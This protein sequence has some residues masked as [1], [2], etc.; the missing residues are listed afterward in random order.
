MIDYSEVYRKRF[1]LI[2]KWKDPDFLALSIALY[3]KDP[4]EFVNTWCETLDPRNSVRNLPNL[5]PLVLFERQQQMVRF[6]LQCMDEEAEGVIEKSREVGATWIGSAISVWLWLFRDDFSIGWGSLLERN[7]DS[8][9]NPSSIFEKMRIIIRNL[10]P[11]LLPESWSSV[12]MK[13]VNHERNN[14]ILGE[15]GDNIGRG[16]RNS[17]YFIDESAHLAR[18]ERIEAALSANARTKIHISSV[19]A[20]AY[21]FQN[22]IKT[23]VPWANGSSGLAQDRSNVFTFDWSD[24]PLMTQEEYDQ[25]RTRYEREGLL[26][27]FKQEYDRDASGSLVDAI[28]MKEWVEA[29]VDAHTKILELGEGAH[30]AAL[31]VADE[32]G[33][34]SALS[35]RKGLT[36]THL[37]D[38][39][40]DTGQTTRKALNILKPIIPKTLPKGQRQNKL[41]LQ[42][43]CIG[44]GA[45]VKAEANRLADEGL[46][47]DNI[48]FVPWN[49]G[50]SVLQ[51][52]APVIP[53]DRDSPTNADHYANLKAQATWDVRNRFEKTYRVIVNGEEYPAEELI[54]ISSTIPS[55]V[56]LR[57]T[58]ELC[59]FRRKPTANLKEGVDKNPNGMRSPDLADSFI[60]NFFPLNVMSA[61][62]KAM[63]DPSIWG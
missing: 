45:G 51:P 62:A 40:A 11:Q 33:D 56:R 57:L 42:Y 31:D 8:S 29:A 26:H 5:L 44:V 3:S 46:L 61:Y 16:G 30:S 28:I 48:E 25:K 41:A 22:K 52:D 36:L 1:R 63:S 9:D 15:G 43:D 24:N 34:F 49:A 27:V 38:W 47:P 14:L 4:I 19:K 50:A 20:G 2:D 21:V 39:S 35:I 18:P 55:D 60:M 59:Q 17:V 54:S 7:V 58:E 32:G 23:G 10:P 53:N 6:V 12:S 13:I 37:E